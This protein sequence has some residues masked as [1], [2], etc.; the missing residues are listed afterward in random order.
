MNG[1]YRLII[2]FYLS[3]W[4]ENYCIDLLFP[5]IRTLFYG[6][7]MITWSWLRYIES[8]I[9]NKEVGLVLVFSYVTRVIFQSTE[10][11]RAQGLLALV[12]SRE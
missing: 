5:E 8:A 1:P 3:L 6:F 11:I 9:W 2:T 4:I 12:S 10:V 7:V